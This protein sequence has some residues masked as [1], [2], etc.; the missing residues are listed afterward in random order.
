MQAKLKSEEI[1]DN[2]IDYL[3]N[4][5]FLTEIRLRG[6]LNDIE[7]NFSGINKN[8]AKALSYSL[9]KNFDRA[10][11]HFELALQ[12]KNMEC[13][14][15]YMAVVNNNCGVSKSVEVADRLLKEYESKT[16]L[17]TA[18][19]LA[20]FRINIAQLEK[21]MEVAMK[22]SN[23]EDRMKLKKDFDSASFAISKFKE[24]AGF[25]NGEEELLSDIV[26][27]I[28]D[29]KNIRIRGVKFIT[30]SK[31]EESINSYLVTVYC[32]DPREIANINM[33]IAFK[34][35]DHDVFLDKKFSTIVQGFSQKEYDEVG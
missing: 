26:L 12:S 18:C 24:F 5:G 7:E 3:S 27:G 9:A 16:I 1:L 32:D 17:K 11:Y 22:L 19:G 31:H 25:N 10:I 29:E 30:D 2:L 13:A 21:Y 33:S 34:L 4:G 8:Y 23:D 6:V 20:I 35:A 14:L 15:N 28:L